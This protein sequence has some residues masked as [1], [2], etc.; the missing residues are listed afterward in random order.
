MFAHYFS[1]IHE[2]LRRSLLWLTV[3]NFHWP[4]LADKLAD[5]P[6]DL[7]FR[8]FVFIYGVKYKLVGVMVLLAG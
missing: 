2:S 6:T 7:L 8:C 1:V 5:E 4:H 3:S